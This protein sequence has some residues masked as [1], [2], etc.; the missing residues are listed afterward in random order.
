MKERFFVFSMV[1][2]SLLAA[3]QD[4]KP[5]GLNVNDSAPEFTA[6]D[7]YGKEVSLTALLKKG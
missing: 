3:A 1:L 5:Q 4:N 2:C 7:Q 6:N